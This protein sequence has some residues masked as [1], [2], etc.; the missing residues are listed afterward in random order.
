[1]LRIHRVLAGRR[2]TITA[3]STSLLRR[4]INT[5]P[6]S[7]DKSATSSTSPPF[8]ETLLRKSRAPLYNSAV[9]PPIPPPLP[10]DADPTFSRVSAASST[11]YNAP[12]PLEQLAVL[13][14]CL[15][16]GDISRSEEVARRITVNWEKSKR[17]N[18]EQESSK[19]YTVLPPRVHADFL[20]AYLSAALT[21]SQVPQRD[22]FSGSTPTTKATP[23]AE[24]KLDAG[25]PILNHNQAKLINKAWMYFDSL[26]GHQWN[27]SDL[28]GERRPTQNGAIDSSVIATLLK[29]LTSAG[30]R[31]YDPSTSTDPQNWQRPITS[32]LP[33]ILHLKLDLLEIMRDSIFDVTLPSYIGAVTRE[34]VL[35]AI[36]ETGKGRLGWEQ[37]ELEIKRVQDAVL[38]DREGREEEARVEATEL[39]PT[40]S[41]S[42]SHQICIEYNSDG[43]IFCASRKTQLQFHY[44]LCEPIFQHSTL[45]VMHQFF[46]PLP[47]DNGCSRNHLTTLLVNFIFTKW[48]NCRK[49]ERIKSGECQVVGYRV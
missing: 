8:P 25:K 18:G 16:S 12:S 24:Q 3:S 2:V 30:P 36:S 11:A 35:E 46:S 29:G 6:A 49:L 20:K 7:T 27:K 43:C 22:Y 23:L 31:I 19:L 4:F 44:K 45:L 40:T 1:M 48:K 34:A 42:D 14:A 5:E 28:K 47:L 21:T 15:V 13:N 26:L 37:W 32:L 9:L 10:V 17:S 39:D 33:H 41:V 38:A